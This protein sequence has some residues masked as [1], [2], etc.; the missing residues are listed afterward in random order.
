MM[1]LRLDP[2]SRRKT[3]YLF[4]QIE[5]EQQVL[6]MFRYH[7]QLPAEQQKM[8]QNQVHATFNPRFFRRLY[9]G[10]RNFVNTLRD[11]FN[12]AIGAAVT[13]YQRTNPVLSTLRFFRDEYM[14]HIVDKTCPAGVC[15]IGRETGK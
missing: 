14:A 12:A 9:R 7:A 4:Y 3:S 11:A 5:L 2:Q 13:Q 1:M 10:L 6:S 8:R 15:A